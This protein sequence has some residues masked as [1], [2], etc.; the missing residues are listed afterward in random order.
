MISQPKRDRTNRADAIVDC[1]S[2]KAALN[3]AR[4]FISRSLAAKQG[5]RLSQIGRIEW[6][7]AAWSEVV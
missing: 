6:S 2:R 1:F 5:G 4:R 7:S 3:V